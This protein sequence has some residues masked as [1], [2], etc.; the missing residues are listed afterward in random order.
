M[1]SLLIIT[2]TFISF[3]YN[4]RIISYPLH[5]F[6]INCICLYINL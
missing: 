4:K 2:Y 3:Y 6:F 5:I 1:Y